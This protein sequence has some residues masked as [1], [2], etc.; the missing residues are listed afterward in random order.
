MNYKEI[1]TNLEETF[2]KSGYKMVY[3]RF[4]DDS[5]NCLGTLMLLNEG[6]EKE[7]KRLIIN[8]N[9]SYEERLQVLIALILKLE[10]STPFETKCFHIT[11]EFNLKPSYIKNLTDI[12]MKIILATH[13]K[14]LKAF[15]K[16][17]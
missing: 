4:N 9:T 10:A 8:L 1:C 11:K 7:E 3:K 16:A 14:D 2:L 6:T 13:G 15:A 17:V 12:A 5:I